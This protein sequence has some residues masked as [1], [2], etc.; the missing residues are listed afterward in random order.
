MGVLIWTGEFTP[1]NIHVSH[2]L[3]SLGLPNF[4]TTREA[5]ADLGG[6]DRRARRLR[7][8][9][10]D[11]LADIGDHDRE[12]DDHDH[13]DDDPRDIERHG[14]GVCPGGVGGVPVRPDPRNATAGRAAAGLGH[15]G[16]VLRFRSTAS[17]ACVRLAAIPARRS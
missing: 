17:A 12:D 16:I 3:Q 8:H 5:L 1:L 11:D 14:H 9:L 13:H 7:L 10:G 6:G 15:V 2:W 4:T